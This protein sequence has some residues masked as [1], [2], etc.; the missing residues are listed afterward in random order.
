MWKEFNF[1]SLRWLITIW[2][3]IW[4]CYS[5]LLI[6][7]LIFFFFF[8]SDCILTQILFVM[9]CFAALGFFREWR[10]VS[11]MTSQFSHHK[12]KKSS[13]QWKKQS[14]KRETAWWDS[15]I[16]LRKDQQHWSCHIVPVFRCSCCPQAWKL[17]TD[18]ILHFGYSCTWPR[19]W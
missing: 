2:K 4:K 12:R 3:V 10:S 8:S 14:P 1:Q 19:V 7:F 6:F 11:W 17:Q 15:N 18:R 13:G 9:A 5:Y 16:Q